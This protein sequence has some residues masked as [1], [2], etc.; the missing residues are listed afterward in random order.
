MD[1]V[2]SGCSNRHFAVLF[3]SLDEIFIGT[4]RIA[5]TV[6]ENIEYNG[7]GFQFGEPFEQAS[8][9]TSMPA[10]LKALLSELLVRF[11][12]KANESDAIDRPIT[13][14]WLARRK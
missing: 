7:F 11:Q 2:T 13:V 5:V 10:L 3:C 14:Q 4:C 12:I 8:M 1:I 6:K 9:E